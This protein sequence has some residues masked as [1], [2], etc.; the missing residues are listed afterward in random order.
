MF[1]LIR[2]FPCCVIE[3]QTCHHQLAHP[4]KQD[5]CAVLC[6]QSQFFVGVCSIILKICSSELVCII[7]LFL[8]FMVPLYGV[9]KIFVVKKKPRGKKILTDR[10][11]CTDPYWAFTSEVIGSVVLFHVVI[12]FCRCRQIFYYQGDHSVNAYPEPNKY[13]NLNEARAKNPMIGGTQGQG[14]IFMQLDIKQM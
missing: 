8:F 11:T 5:L 14:L 9:T 3:H 10:E 4:D 7:L 6:P 1:L 13:A 12:M 2:V